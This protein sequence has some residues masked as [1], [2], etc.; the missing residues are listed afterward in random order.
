MAKIKER[1]NKELSDKGEE[2]KKSRM[3]DTG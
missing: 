3:A 2:I 1:R